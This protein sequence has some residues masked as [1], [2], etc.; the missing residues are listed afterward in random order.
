M[1]IEYEHLQSFNE[2]DSRFPSGRGRLKR[3]LLT[4]SR[5]RLDI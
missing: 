5:A 3:V 4:P 2:T 1:G